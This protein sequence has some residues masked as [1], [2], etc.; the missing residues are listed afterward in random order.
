[1]PL[2]HALLEG[3]LDRLAALGGG[4]FD[5]GQPFKGHLREKRAASKKNPERFNARGFVNPRFN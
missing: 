4:R 5:I 2:T 1:M 3:V